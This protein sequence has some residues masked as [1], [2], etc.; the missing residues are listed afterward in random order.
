MSHHATCPNCG[1]DDLCDNGAV[2]LHEV[3]WKCMHCGWYLETCVGCGLPHI[4][5]DRTRDDLC[6][7]CERREQ[8]ERRA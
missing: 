4:D 8:A 3:E 1:S 5:E 6:E 7:S 2:R